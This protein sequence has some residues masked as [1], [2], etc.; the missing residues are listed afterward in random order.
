MHNSARVWWTVAELFKKLRTD[1]DLSATLGRIPFDTCKFYRF[2]QPIKIDIKLAATA[3]RCSVAEWVDIAHLT[4]IKS[5]V[6]RRFL[7]NKYVCLIIELPTGETEKAIAELSQRHSKLFGCLQITVINP[8]KWSKEDVVFNMKGALKGKR[9]CHQGCYDSSGAP[10]AFKG[11]DCIHRRAETSRKRSNYI[12][13]SQLP[14]VEPPSQL[15]ELT[16]GQPRAFGSPILPEPSS[17]DF[18]TR[19]PFGAEGGRV[20]GDGTSVPPMTGYEQAVGEIFTP[21]QMLNILEAL[22]LAGVGGNLEGLV[23]DGAQ[24][25]PLDEQSAGASAVED[26]VSCSD[27]GIGAL[28]A[29]EDNQVGDTPEE[30]TEHGGA[31]QSSHAQNKP[32]A[33]YISDDKKQGK[34]HSKRC[35]R[36]LEALK[37]LQIACRPYI[38]LF[39]ARPE[40]ILTS[41]GKA[42]AFTSPALKAVL[43][44]SSRDLEEELY[45]MTKKHAQLERLTIRDITALNVQVH[46]A[47]EEL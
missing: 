41:N 16:N 45:T 5:L 4:E 2:E 31:L 1:P 36:V 7:T 34:A 9:H 11:S 32:C 28:P 30:A 46:H 19:M 35:A 13:Q 33:V 29:V 27:R 21:E 26:T 44:A 8:K 17:F 37:W 42:F 40:T 22:G 24:D 20:G 25:L 6:K 47:E 12:Q 10:A 23:V 39:I 3:R 15:A 43:K 18:Q 38:F 14:R